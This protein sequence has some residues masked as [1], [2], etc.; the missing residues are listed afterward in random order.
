VD[1]QARF[2]ALVTELTGLPGVQPPDVEGG[3]RFGA[4][5]IRL[6][7]SIVAMLVDGALVLKL[8]GDRVADLVASGRGT[9]WDG[10]QGRRMRQWIVVDDEDLVRT[11]ALGFEALDFARARPR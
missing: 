1:A 6:D 5:T 7:G 2:N 3:R 8:P 9:P 11:L 10:G 4:D